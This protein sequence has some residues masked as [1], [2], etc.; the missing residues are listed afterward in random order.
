MGHPYDKEIHIYS[1]EVPGF[2]NVSDQI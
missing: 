1:N 2:T